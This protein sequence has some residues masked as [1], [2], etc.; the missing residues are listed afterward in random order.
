[1]NMRKFTSDTFVVILP[2][3]MFLFLSCDGGNTG[4]SSFSE[5]ADSDHS[6]SIEIDSVGLDENLPTISYE[7]DT[8][9]GVVVV[10]F[11]DEIQYSLDYE[12]LDESLVGLKNEFGEEYVGKPLLF[13]SCRAL[14]GGWLL[15]FHNKGYPDSDYW[16]LAVDILNPN[17]NVVKV[18][19]FGDGEI[20]ESIYATEIASDLVIVKTGYIYRTDEIFL[21]TIRIDRNGSILDSYSF[22]YTLEFADGP[23]PSYPIRVL[24]SG[25][26]SR[27]IIC[28]NTRINYIDAEGKLVSKKIHHNSEL[29]PNLHFLQMGK[30]T[31]KDDQ[32]FVSMVQGSFEDLMIIDDSVSYVLSVQ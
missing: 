16:N 31:S 32:I 1:M 18:I 12:S 28:D 29:D 11:N 8:E 23:P 24:E 15:V 13:D 21:E 19:A 22:D 26:A 2:I 5:V 9:E 10:F 7:I 6:N 25:D 27:L 4:Q 14:S 20:S 3:A 17:G 30:V